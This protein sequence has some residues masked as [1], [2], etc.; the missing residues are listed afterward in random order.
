M[1]EPVKNDDRFSLF[2][3]AARPLR[4]SRV[5]KLLTC[6]MSVFLAEDES[7]GN[8]A[9]QTGNLVHSAAAEYH[10]I[11]GTV[12]Q[13]T[14]AGLA[15]IAAAR[16]QFPDG[17]QEKAKTIF[18]AYAADKTNQEADVTHV[19]FPVRLDLESPDGVPIVI[20]GTLD[21]I[22]SGKVWDIKTGGRLDANQT[23]EEYLVQQAVYTLAARQTTGL[24]I[25]PGGIIYTP[26]YE[27]PRGRRHLPLTISVEQCKLIVTGVVPIVVA[28]RQGTPQFRPSAEACKY[29]PV[30]PFSN[31]LS[32]FKGVF[33]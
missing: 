24:D 12:D 29:C 4:P 13:R 10:R 9:A 2:G 21:Q 6:P 3:T 25:Q 8:V 19:E 16:D 31:C 14:E 28:L 5:H 7:V 23:V 26:G 17:N 33:R 32:M 1:L 18:T 22:R 30:R 11:T 27:K 20:Q 15:A